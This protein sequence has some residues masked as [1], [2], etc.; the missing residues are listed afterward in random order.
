MAT[1]FK[2]TQV[3]SVELDLEPG[4]DSR[5]PALFTYI[6]FLLLTSVLSP[7]QGPGDDVGGEFSEVFATG[8]LQV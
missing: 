5:V 7:V 1:L 2:V 6:H 4:V 3:L 8:K